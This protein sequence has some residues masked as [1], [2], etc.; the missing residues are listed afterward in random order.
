MF[1]CAPSIVFAS[2]YSAEQVA[3]IFLDREKFDGASVAVLAQT[4]R[5]R[6]IDNYFLNCIRESIGVACRHE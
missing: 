5:E 3:H 6:K 4:P 2:C 1:I